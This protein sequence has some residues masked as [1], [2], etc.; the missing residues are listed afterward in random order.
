MKSS[1]YIHIPFCVSKCS[2][3]DFVS[4]SETSLISTYMEALH[5][6][7][8]AF[9]DTHEPI[10]VPTIFIGGGTPS[11]LTGESIRS[12]LR[13]LKERFLITRDCEITM[14]CNPN[15]VCEE[16]ADI[17]VKAG[18]NRFS[19][20][21]Q[22]ASEET[23][24][25][26]GRVHTV[27]DYEP[28]LWILRRN[29]IQNINTDI[30]LGTPGETK[31]ELQF[32][33]QFVTNQ[34]PTH[35][36]AYALQIEQGTPLYRQHMQTDD[37]FIADC[38]DLT[39]GFLQ[40]IGYNRYEVSNFSLPGY[41]CRH[42]LVYWDYADYVGFGASAHSFFQGE[43]FYNVSDVRQYIDRVQQGVTPII[44]RKKIE[45]ADAIEEFIMLGFRKETGIDL[46]EYARRF[47]S[48]FRQDFSQPLQDQKDFL[49]VTDS[50]V[51][52]RPEYMYIG[53][54]ITIKFFR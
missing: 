40:K 2:Y 30:I 47:H 35:I 24:Q 17:Y 49:N 33:L 20:G 53:N 52:I 48:D 37:D 3:C 18:V 7:I 36:S 21:L 46:A 11:L 51:A 16:N 26:L 10:Q 6:E 45:R 23:L 29:G 14:E 27:S 25:K 12:L 50:H 41:A 43:R 42:N 8:I 5:K 28:A 22:S 31:Q 19:I 32:T 38:Y 4:I 44:E 15:S 1:I 54:T 9:S 13:L 39:A 34:E